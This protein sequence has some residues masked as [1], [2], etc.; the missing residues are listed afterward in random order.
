[1]SSQRRNAS[2]SARYGLALASARQRHSSTL[3]PALHQLAAELAHHARLAHAGLAAHHREARSLV[4]ARRSR[5]LA[6][7]AR[8]ADR[9]VA[10]AAARGRGVCQAV[11]ASGDTR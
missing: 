2:A 9:P 7:R 3:T 6:A 5:R 4:D 8:C 1:M 11:A 10:S